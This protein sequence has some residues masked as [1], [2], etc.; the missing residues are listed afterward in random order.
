MTVVTPSQVRVAKGSYLCR[1][2]HV[3]GVSAN[4]AGLV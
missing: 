2:L 3:L 4:K 1:P